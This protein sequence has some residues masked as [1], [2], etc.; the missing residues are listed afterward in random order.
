MAKDDSGATR[1]FT[2]RLSRETME[3][4]SVIQESRKRHARPISPA[5]VVDDAI[6]AYYDLLVERG[7]L[8]DKE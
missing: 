5:S 6:K 3:L 1:P 2:I 4:I 8:N 7:Q